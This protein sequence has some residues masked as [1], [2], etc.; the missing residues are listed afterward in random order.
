MISEGTSF[1][2]QVSVHVA[3][4]SVKD[5]LDYCMLIFPI[6]TA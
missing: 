1:M 4:K 3:A 2:E 5:E 6:A